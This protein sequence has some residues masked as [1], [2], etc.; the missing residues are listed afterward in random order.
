MTSWISR[1][2]PKK[3]VA[4]EPVSLLPMNLGTFKPKMKEV[5]LVSALYDIPDTHPFKQR[6]QW[7]KQICQDTS[8]QL[9]VFTDPQFANEI[10]AFRK[11]Q[12]ARTRIVALPMNQWVSRTKFNPTVW[13][14][15]VSQDPEL[16]LN[17]TLE[18]FHFGFEKK[19]FMVKAVEMNPFQSDDFVWFDPS[20]VETDTLVNSFNSSKIPIDTILVLN[21]EPFTAD[22]L[23][24][25]YFKGKNRVSNLVLAASGQQWKEYAKLYD[26]VMNLKLRVSSFIGD[27]LLMLH[28]VIIHKPSQFCLV[29]QDSLVRY[30]S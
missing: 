25:S 29:K 15:Q 14:Q 19:E 30:L 28:Y 7:L 3:K 8:G 1:S 2:L 13:N 12:E 6:K 20:I 21:P 23:A 4:P 11:D 24:S 16:R 18:Q 17:R 22:D 9:I 10:A 26:V 5:T 27:D